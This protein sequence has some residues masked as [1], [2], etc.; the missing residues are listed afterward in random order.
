MENPNEFV[1]RMQQLCA[2]AGV[3]YLLVPELPSMGVSGVTRWLGER[4]LIQQCLRFKTNDH[5]WFT[6]FHEARH[7]LQ[8]R[9][10]H[11]FI[12]APGL[13]EEDVAHEDD[14]N[15]FAAETLIPAK[16]YADNMGKGPGTTEIRAFARRIGV[17]PGI[18]VGR[19]Q[20]DKVLAYG[21]PAGNLK[22]KFEWAQR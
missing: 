19:L 21:H 17:H 8:N 12:E 20:R 22:V 3:L 7:V 11:V 10:R 18:V 4:P 9:R 16:E 15:R 2:D 6:F 14:A 5:F 1:P 13:L